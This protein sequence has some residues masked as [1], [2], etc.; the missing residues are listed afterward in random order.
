[1]FGVLVNISQFKELRYR[2]VKP[3]FISIILKSLTFRSDLK[4]YLSA[5]FLANILSEGKVFWEKY[6]KENTE[7]N[8]NSV[9]AS[10]RSKISEWKMSTN[11]LN[12]NFVIF[13]PFNRLLKCDDKIPQEVHYYSVWTLAHFTR[14]DC[15]R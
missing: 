4:S 14:K 15:Q 1:M 13:K 6:F 7:L 9:L 12:I 10:M 5:K 8:I 3:E 11:E 2:I